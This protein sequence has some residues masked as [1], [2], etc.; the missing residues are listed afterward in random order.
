MTQYDAQHFLKLQFI[1]MQCIFYKG[2]KMVT[3]Y[4]GVKGEL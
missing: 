4:L 2:L 1:L 3:C